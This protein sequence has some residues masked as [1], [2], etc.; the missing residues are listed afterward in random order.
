MQAKWQRGFTLIELMIVVA[1]IGI[2]AAIAIP[3]Y[4]TYVARSQF[5][6]AVSESGSVKA[7]TES[8]IVEG[9]TQGVGVALNECDLQA[10]VTGSTILQGSNAGV[11][12]P[13]GTGAPVLTFGSPTRIVATFGNAVS[14]MLNGGSVVWSRDNASGTW[15]C[16]P[17][18]VPATFTIPG[19]R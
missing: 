17:A 18:G 12:V 14:P 19:C 6:R 8:C 5:S 9:K 16:S 15:T 1:I 11:A 2:L 10:V 3:Q 13:L 7:A 4:Q